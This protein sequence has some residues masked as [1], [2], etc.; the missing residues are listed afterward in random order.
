V[1]SKSGFKKKLIK[2]TEPFNY[3]IDIPFV[4]NIS[5]HRVRVRIESY[6]KEDD[7][8]FY[9]ILNKFIQQVVLLCIESLKIK[10]RIH[11]HLC[12]QV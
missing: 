6:E 8:N 12:R 10:T 1:D 3:F 11:I 5:G 4:R 7:V 2:I 9:L